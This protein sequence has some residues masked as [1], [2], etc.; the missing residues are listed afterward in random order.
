MVY[1]FQNQIDN[2]SLGA[3]IY[4]ASLVAQ[5]VKNLPAMWETWVHF[6]GWEDA[7][8]K[9]TATHSSVLAQEFPWTEEPDGLQSRGH[10][11]SDT[12]ERLELSLQM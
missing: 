4:W 2:L 12:T 5:T 8:E 10:K 3:S 1:G 7:L 11:E 9:G 6:L